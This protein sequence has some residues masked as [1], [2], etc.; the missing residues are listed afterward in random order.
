MAH[1]VFISHSSKDKAVADATCAWLEASGV[2][3]WVAHRNI[4]PGSS[5]GTS[6]IQAIRA[7]R[8]MVLIF[9]NHAN[10]SPQITREVE[11]A[12]NFGK[13]IIPM[14]IEDVLPE[15]DMEYFLGVPHWLNAYSQPL[16][17][18]LDE[19]VSIVK[20]IPAIPGTPAET[21]NLEEVM[22]GPMPE[23]ADAP[24]EEAMEVPE[25]TPEQIPQPVQRVEE[26]TP[27]ASPPSSKKS[28]APSVP[29]VPFLRNAV[30]AFG[31]YLEKTAAE[32]RIRRDQIAYEDALR[33]EQ[34]LEAQR[35]AKREAE[36]LKEAELEAQAK[37]AAQA[38]AEEAERRQEAERRAAEEAAA[39]QR[40]REIAAAQKAE[41]DAA[42]AAL[43][44]YQPKAGQEWTNSLEMKFV[45]AGTDGVLFCTGTVR[46]QDWRAFVQA[47]GYKQ[48]GGI[49]VMKAVENAKGIMSLIW[50]LDPKASWE[51][52]GFDQGPTHPVVG[53]SWN[54]AET[55][56]QWLTKKEQGEG[57]L[58]L[59]QM[60]RLPTDAEWTTAAGDGKYPWGDDWPPPEGAGN[61]GDEA[62]ASRLPGK[63][64]QHIPGNS[65]YSHTSPVGS[66]ASNA[67][68]LYDMG[69][70]VWQWCEND[71]P[72]ISDETMKTSPASE[73][74]GLTH[75]VLRG[76][77][78]NTKQSVD[79][80]CACR[81]Y[82]SPDNRKDSCGFRCVVA[83]S[84]R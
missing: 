65:G 45:P 76:A 44:A 51:R 5:W 56:C 83:V 28:R 50:A 67:Y 12:V 79:L 54:D 31:S 57:R 71:S 30:T 66:F 13:R 23:K 6:I 55:F 43:A 49:F 26:T 15:G 42:A 63:G 58:G 7:S 17:T 73:A 32:K 21:T 29:G 34:E 74:G 77:A 41:A 8:V 84:A 11:R 46:V 33:K 3:C 24:A 78:W 75:R 37:A 69:G 80:R 9:S 35:Q 27:P 22:A 81:V 47:T 14:R 40:A 48:T 53:V 10:A 1:D 70:N 16:E 2:S 19:L 4:R 20:E 82:A 18:H 68:G 60:Y 39:E 25:V 38:A 61:Y 36:A 62:F 59:H 52:P 64:W 72:T